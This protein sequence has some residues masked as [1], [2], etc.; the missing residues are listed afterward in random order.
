MDKLPWPIGEYVFHFGAS[1]SGAVIRYDSRI[2]TYTILLDRPDDCILLDVTRDEFKVIE[3]KDSK[4]A[5]MDRHATMNK[6]Q[7]NLIIYLDNIIYE[8]DHF[9]D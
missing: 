1:H 8:L 5:V 4:G 3:R 7:D 6:L 9:D 2:P